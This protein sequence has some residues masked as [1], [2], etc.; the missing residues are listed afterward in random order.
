MIFA[1]LVISFSYGGYV[2]YVGLI[3]LSLI[4][5]YLSA[6]S[7]PQIEIGEIHEFTENG[8]HGHGEVTIK[9]TYYEEFSLLNSAFI[10]FFVSILFVTI[11]LM[12]Y[13]NREQI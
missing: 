13:D 6:F 5:L 3:F 7:P 11:V 1:L 10:L 12:I 8:T 4:G 2:I 9:E